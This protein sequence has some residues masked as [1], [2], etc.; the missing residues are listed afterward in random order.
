MKHAASVHP[1]PGSNSPLSEKFMSL[2]HLSMNRSTSFY[3][4]RFIF[5]KINR[6]ISSSA[7][8]LSMFYFFSKLFGHSFEIFYLFP[9]S[10]Q[11]SQSLT[12]VCD[13]FYPITSILFVN[14]FFKKFLNLFFLRSFGLLITF[15]K[16]H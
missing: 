9:H 5:F 11:I 12:S 3:F 8:L 15:L 4:V 2:V 10:L 13:I 16:N 6:Y 14:K 7:I 1:E